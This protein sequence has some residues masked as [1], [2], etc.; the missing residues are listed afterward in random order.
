VEEIGMNNLIVLLCTCGSEE[1]GLRIAER[2]VESKLAACVNLLEGVRSVYR[3]Q[4]KVETSQE[5][6]LLIKSVAERFEEIQAR[7]TELHS[8]DT[9]EIIALPIIAGS[10]K[11]LAW[12]RQGTSADLTNNE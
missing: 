1:E 7:I 6:L 8:Y 11:Y 10:E 2:L 12:I 5:V 4:G 9:P 3:W